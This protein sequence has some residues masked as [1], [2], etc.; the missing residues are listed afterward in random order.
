MNLKSIFAAVILLVT[1]LEFSAAAA[2][3]K[4]EAQLIWGTSETKPADPKLKPADA[5]VRRK[6]ASLPLKWTNFYEVNRQ[7]LTLAPT[8]TKKSALSDRCAVEVKHLGGDKIEVLLLGKG[9]EVGKVTQ[10][11]PRGEILV[12]AGNA[13]AESAWLVTLKR[14]E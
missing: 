14:I 10:H 3:L 9:K 4:L 5:E 1:M 13:P 12:L 11:L 6:L 2:E 8:E 7:S